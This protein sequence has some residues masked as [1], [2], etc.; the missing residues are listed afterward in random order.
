MKC[1]LL[2]ALVKNCNMTCVFY[3]Y[4]KMHREDLGKRVLFHYSGIFRIYMCGP[5]QEEIFSTDTSM[6]VFGFDLKK[7]EKNKYANGFFLSS[8]S[9]HKRI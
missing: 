1:I 6:D 5:A 7:M 4:E 3:R 2:K 8:E 9:S